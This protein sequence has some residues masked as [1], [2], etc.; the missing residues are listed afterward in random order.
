MNTLLKIINKLVSFA[1]VSFVR[2][3]ITATCRN[4]DGSV[5]WKEEKKNLIATVG[6]AVFAQRLAQDYTYTGAIKYGALGSSTTA[7]ANG[8]TQLGTEV[9]RKAPASYSATSN[10]AYITFVYAVAEA[11]GTHREF[12]TFIDGS[13][14]A[15]TGILFSHLAVNWVK[16]GVQSLTVDCVYTIS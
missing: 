12:G 5:A 15:N 9:F 4:A 6:R 8:D 10:K 1:G 11:I 7:P 14:S 16:T 3:N 13:A 2:Y